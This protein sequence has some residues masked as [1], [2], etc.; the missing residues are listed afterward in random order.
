MVDPLRLI[1]LADAAK[2]LGTDKDN[3][4]ALIGEGS[5]PCVRVGA[6]GELRVSV[7]MIEAW[8]RGVG[9]R[10]AAGQSASQT[11][12]PKGAVGRGPARLRDAS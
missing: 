6:R 12:T 8:S 1:G 7:A 5:F 11:R 4:R 2:I 3:L 9:E 10:A